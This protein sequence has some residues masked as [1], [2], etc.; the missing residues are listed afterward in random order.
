V[1]RNLFM[2]SAT[3]QTFR[4]QQKYLLQ[5]EKGTCAD[6]SLLLI[7]RLSLLGVLCGDT[8]SEMVNRSVFLGTPLRVSAK[9]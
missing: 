4:E 6:S 1:K 9:D 3:R 7:P 8:A 2:V 5:S